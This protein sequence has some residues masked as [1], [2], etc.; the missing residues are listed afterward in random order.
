MLGVEELPLHNCHRLEIGQLLG[1]LQML[2]SQRL[3]QTLLNFVATLCIHE[4][5]K[6]GRL[7]QSEFDASFFSEN[8]D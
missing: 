6:I 1:D 7:A 8:F 2:D 4:L 5:F 3:H